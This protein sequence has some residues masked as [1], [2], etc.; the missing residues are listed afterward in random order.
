LLAEAQLVDESEEDAC[1]QEYG[2]SLARTWVAV[3]VFPPVVELV[4]VLELE[5]EVELELEFELLLLLELAPSS[6][7]LE[8]PRLDCFEPF[9]LPVL[10]DFE[11][12]VWEVLL[13]GFFEPSSSCVWFQAQRTNSTISTM[14]MASAN[15]RVAQRAHE[16]EPF[17]GAS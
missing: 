6:P 17:C 9:E 16:R 14:T 2:D 7:S 13:V 5:L 11:L 15:N 10:E 3:P 12:S 1:R 4:D 8:P